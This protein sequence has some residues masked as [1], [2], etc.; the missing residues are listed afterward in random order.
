M[1]QAERFA[2]HDG[3]LGSFGRFMRGVETRRRNRVDGRIHGLDALN[4]RIE[5]FNRR[6]GFCADQAAQFDGGQADQLGLV[7]HRSVS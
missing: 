5:Q 3:L 6:N 4:A 2:V 7:K 1:Q